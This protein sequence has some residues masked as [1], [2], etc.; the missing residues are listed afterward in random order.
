M[1]KK[2]RLNRESAILSRQISLI[3]AIFISQIWRLC[4]V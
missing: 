4:E 1:V 3:D 2:L